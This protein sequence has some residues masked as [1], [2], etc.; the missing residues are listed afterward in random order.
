MIGMGGMYYSSKSPFGSSGFETR[1]GGCQIERPDFE[2]S[3]F[4]EFGRNLRISC[5]I[6]GLPHHH[7]TGPN[8]RYLEEK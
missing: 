7:D 8:R 1:A 6:V 4:A 3:Q 2:N 5:H